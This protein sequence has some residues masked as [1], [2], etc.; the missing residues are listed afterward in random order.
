MQ[1]VTPPGPGGEWVDHV[2]YPDTSAPEYLVARA[3]FDERRRARRARLMAALERDG[4]LGD[5]A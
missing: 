4:L 3:A 2:F 1:R 5:D